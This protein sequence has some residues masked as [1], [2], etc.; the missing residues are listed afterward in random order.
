MTRNEDI[1]ILRGI[2]VSLV[3]LF[4]SSSITI[5]AGYLGV[6]IFFV[7][8]G[9]LITSHIIRDVDRQTFSLTQFYMRRARRLLPATYCTLSLTTLGALFLLVP[10]SWNAYIKSLFG[11]LTF[12]AN[13]FLWL[14]TGY[15]DEAA[16]SKPL[17]HLWSLSIE[18]QYYLV[19]P[20]FLLIVPNRFRMLLIAA[21]LLSSGALCVLLVSY[22]PSATFFLLPTRAWELMVG[23]FLAGLLAKHP[24]LEAPAAL[25]VV[26]TA[27]IVIIPFFP[28]DPVHPRFDALL[29]TCATAVLLTGR[30]EWLRLGPVTRGLSLAGDWSYSIYLVHWPLY[31]FATGVFVGKIPMTVSLIFIPVSFALGYLQYRYVEQ[32]FRFVWREN[33]SR[34]LR[35]VVAASLVV[36]LPIPLYLTG[37]IASAGDI[38]FVQL[39]RANY[40]LDPVCEY[41]GDAFDNKPQCRLS[42]APNVA[43]WGD[44]FAMHWAA[45]LADALHDEGLIQATKS[46]CG[47][48]GRLAIIDDKRSRQSAN[49]C[50]QFNNSVLHFITTTDSIKTVVLSAAIGYYIRSEVRGFLIDDQVEEPHSKTLQRQFLE[51]IS[52]LRLAGKHVIVIAPPPNPGNGINVGDCLERRARGLVAFLA[53]RSDCAFN[54]GS[55]R[56]RSHRVIELLRKFEGLDGVDL[57]W[58]ESVM[59]ENE[60]CAARIGNILLYRDDGHL[61]YDGSVLVARMLHIANNLKIR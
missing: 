52:T 61:T 24:G 19:L 39:R 25:K 23:S 21:A 12:T 36:S 58:P 53:G 55:Y 41:E 13:I 15:F 51:T 11:A 57:V 35:Y 4:H 38:D 59:C 44:S 31:A 46:V 56:A 37:A 8:S 49:N 47:P 6:D 54:Y 2:A 18:E 28:V 16:A 33:N 60:T 30:G 34:Y 9:F 14:Q 48:F 40:G 26:A 20:I 17:L 43:L 50:I 42:G 32:P 45:G 29:V 22:K 27:I 1:Q 5:P 10:F 7:I 3:V